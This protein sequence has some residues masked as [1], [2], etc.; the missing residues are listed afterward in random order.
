M[1]RSSKKG[2]KRPSKPPKAIPEA[3][4]SEPD[5]T[6]NVANVP[7]AER[8]ESDVNASTEGEAFEVVDSP[9]GE[10]SARPTVAAETK[11]DER[12]TDRALGRLLHVATYLALALALVYL[13]PALRKYRPWVAGVD[14]WP[15]L[16]RYADHTDT[17]ESI[18]NG[19]AAEEGPPTDRDELA[20]QLGS[21]VAANLSVGNTAH[22]GPRTH[23]METEYEGLSQ[24]IVDATGSGMRPFYDSLLRTA[25]QEAHA[26]TRVAH[27]GDSSIATDRITS[28]VRRNLQER[29]GD[30]GHGFVLVGNG[31]MAYRHIGLTH[32]MSDAWHTQEVTRQSRDDG[33]YGFGGI[34]LRGGGGARSTL[35][36]DPESP[37]GKTVSRFEIWYATAP[38]LGEI[39]L[40]IDGGEPRN[41]YT[42]SDAPSDGVHVIDVPDGDHRMSVRALSIVEIYGVVLER[43]VPGVVY[44]SLGLVGARASRLLNFDAAHIQSQIRRRG[45]NLLVLGFGGNEASDYIDPAVYEASF[46]QVVQRM[47]ADRTDLGCLVVA[48]LDQ[49][50][51]EG[52]AIRTF[53]GLPILIEAQKRVAARRGCAYF[54]TFAAMGGSGSMARWYRSNPPLASGDFRHATPEGYEV[55]GNMIYR[56]ILEGFAGYLREVGADQPAP[57]H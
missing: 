17:S 52:G 27:Y 28:T 3:R 35:G 31:S 48:P 12:E 10:S 40:R 43:D 26:I 53:R 22:H 34:V 6:A 39:E 20:A 8:V 11:D 42:M 15:V 30:A 55:I 45:T 50:G 5:E 33:R 37:V 4:T 18:A 57:A 29:F 13:V 24:H 49:A 9:R 1:G 47:R 41:V 14:P 54:D 23:I 32:T 51:R 36:S 16:A 19:G 25:R 38:R 2:G 7:E 46:D 21:S 56:A 44:D